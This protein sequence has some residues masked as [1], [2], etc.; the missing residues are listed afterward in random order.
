MS[1]F[2]QGDSVRRSGRNNGRG[3]KIGQLAV[4]SEVIDCQTI[5]VKYPGYFNDFRGR[6]ELWDTE[7][8]ELVENQIAS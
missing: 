1:R 4:V 8:A 6:G 2:K 3:A 7:F 5:L